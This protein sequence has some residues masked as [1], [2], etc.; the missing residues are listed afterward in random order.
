M[1]RRV[2]CCWFAALLSL[3]DNLRP[4]LSVILIVPH[5]TFVVGV[6]AVGAE[7]DEA[8]LSRAIGC[9]GVCKVGRGL[10]FRLVPPACLPLDG[11]PPAVES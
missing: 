3:G 8:G 9:V 4:W 11:G 2:A 1:L 7:E 6:G 10:V 5:L